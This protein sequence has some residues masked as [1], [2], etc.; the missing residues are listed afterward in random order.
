M[1]STYPVATQKGQASAFVINC[2]DPQAPG[3]SSAVV[4]TSAHVL[5]T[6]GDGPLIIGLRNRKAAGG[7]DEMPLVLIPEKQQKRQFYVRH[8]TCDIAAFWVR[9]P[10]AIKQQAD[11]TTVLNDQ[12]LKRDR[13]QLHTGDDVSMLGYPEV[14]PGTEGG[15]AVLRSGKVASYPVGT[16]SANKLF[17]INTDVYPGDSGAPIFIS[18]RD[19]RPRLVGILSSR[20]ATH[21][22]TFSHLAVAVD[23]D[24]IRE[25]IALLM[26]RAPVP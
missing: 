16:P 13:V 5:E 22:A 15:F 3:K 23:A 10:T 14:L 26:A 19:G 24:G 1:W 17:L 2:E 25:T 4:L 18:A 6:I 7:A 21:E 11:L 12:L 8:P 20:I 9:L